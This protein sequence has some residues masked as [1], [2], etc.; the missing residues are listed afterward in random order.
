MVAADAT[1]KGAGESKASSGRGKKA[2]AEQAATPPAAPTTASDGYS[3]ALSA[4]IQCLTVLKG[5][6]PATASAVLAVFAPDVA[7]FMSDE[8]KM[9]GLQ[10]TML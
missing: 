6:G 2:R 1:T 3:T 10:C 5:V 4:A 7:P 9:Q 8:V